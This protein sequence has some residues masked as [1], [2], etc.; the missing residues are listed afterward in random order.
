MKKVI[1]TMSAALVLLSCGPSAEEV[2]EKTRTGAMNMVCNCFNANQ[3]DWLAYK[4]DCQ[5]K[6]K[7]ARYLLSEDAEGLKQLEEKIIECD[8]YFKE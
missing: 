5:T 6:V 7:T 4:K 2:K 1:L 3:G 8:I